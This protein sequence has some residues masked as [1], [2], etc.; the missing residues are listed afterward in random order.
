VY[1]DT[2][3]YMDQLLHRLA[4][5]MTDT[6]TGTQTETDRRHRQADTDRQTQTG[7]CR[8]KDGHTETDTQT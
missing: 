2:D 6:H 8:Y 5:R 1:V 3:M 7:T 4:D